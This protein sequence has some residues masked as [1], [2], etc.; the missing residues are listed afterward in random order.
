MPPPESAE[1]LQANVW[2]VEGDSKWQISQRDCD[3]IELS[4]IYSS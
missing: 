4:C 2:S 3:Q 1:T